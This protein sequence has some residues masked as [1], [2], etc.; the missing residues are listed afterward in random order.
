MEK[1]APFNS[2]A[3]SQA[4]L[5]IGAGRGFVVEGRRGRFII[6]AAHCLPFFPP[7]MSFSFN[8]ERTYQS[9]VGEIGSEPSVWAECLFVDPIADIAVLGTPDDQDLPEQ[10]DEYETLLKKA[11]AVFPIGQIPRVARAWLLSLDGKWFDCEV[12]HSGGPLW[13]TKA[14]RGIEGG[15]SG[16]PILS[17]DGIAVGIVVAG[18]GIERGSEQ[19]PTGGGPNPWL[20][21]NL[22]GWLLSEIG[23]RG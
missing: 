11:P 17:D 9:L 1:R 18:G 4:V 21:G 14:A 22:P 6:T 5:T 15:M 7:C 13:I 16:S 12:G 23:S 10:S 19:A 2:V 20:A 8:E 3:A